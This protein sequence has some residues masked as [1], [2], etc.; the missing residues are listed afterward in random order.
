MAPTL[1]L[2]VAGLIRL[3]ELPARATAIR[4][5]MKGAREKAAHRQTRSRDQ[6]AVDPNTEVHGGSVVTTTGNVR[7]DVTMT[8]LGN[9]AQRATCAVTS[10]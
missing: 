5:E 2:T 3:T 7:G 10:Q 4:E 1:V 8:I 9:S 6:L